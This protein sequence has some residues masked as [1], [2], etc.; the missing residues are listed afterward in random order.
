[1]PTSKPVHDIQAGRLPTEQYAKTFCDKKP[2]LDQLSAGTESSRCYFCYDAPCIQACPT[3]INI[4]QFIRRI[5]TGNLKG[6]A[7][8][9]LSANIMGGTCARVCPVE[10]LCEKACVRNTSEDKPVMIGQLQ[11]YATDYLFEKALQPFTRAPTTGK[12]VAVIGAG[13]A[14]MACAHKLATLGHNVTVFEAKEKAGGLNE[15]GLAAYKMVDNFAQKEID[16]ILAVGGIEIR[17]DHAL[18]EK[19]TLAALRKDYDATF[20]GAGLTGVNSLGIPGENL[21][22]VVD[23]V[24]TIE[25]IRQSK[26]LAK[27]PVPRRVVV[28]GGGNT[29]IDIAV[30]IKLLGAQDVTLVY[31]RGTENMGATWAERELAQ[32]NGVLIKTFAKP[33]KINGDA[34]GVTSIEFEQVS[35]DV[36]KIECDTVFKAIGQTLVPGDLGD[37]PEVLTIEKGRIIVNAKGRTN[38]SKVYAGG[39]C[40]NGGVLTVNSV[41]DGKIAALAIHEELSGSH[42][43][44]RTILEEEEV[45]G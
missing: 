45:H 24:D 23:A 7:T 44:A 22:G 8:E 3:E 27:L 28:I 21:P 16:F 9:I 10:T 31:R 18:G 5:S 36:F 2:P 12:K 11:R 13:P 20:I 26:D 32:K 42:A 39:D 40:V 4:P 6:A 34:G 33:V 38:L 37:A 41:Q 14:G 29:A 25:K 1:M 43:N 30:Q 17:Y 35:G 19:I 15:Y